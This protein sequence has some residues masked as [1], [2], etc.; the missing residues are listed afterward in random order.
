MGNKRTPKREGRP[1]RIPPAPPAPDVAST[2]RSL[3]GVAAGGGDLWLVLW[4]TL[5]DIWLWA[6]V[7]A[8]ERAGLFGPPTEE[9]RGRVLRARREAPE[10]TEAL[11]TFHLLQTAPG[12]PD[13]SQI[14]HACHLV[15]RWAEQESLLELAA[16]YAE[17]AAL[18]NPED[19]ANANE[20]ARLCRRAALSRRAVTWYERAHRLG[21]R[22]QNRREIVWALLGYGSL[23]YG[24]GLY[25]RAR[26]HFERV[27]R[28]AARTGRRHTA[29]EAHHD[30]ILLC[31]DMG[32]LAQAEEHARLA[33]SLYPLRARRI[34]YLVHDCAVLLVR[35]RHY[36]PALSMLRKLPPAFPRPEE[37]ALVWSTLAQAAAGAAQPERYRDAERKAL[38]LVGLYEEHAA[39]ALVS[40]AHGARFLGDDER[41]VRFA[42]MA[43]E[44]AKRRN[45]GGEVRRARAVLKEIELKEPVPD[46]APAPEEVA[47]LA[48]RLAARLRMWKERRPQAPHDW[49]AGGDPPAG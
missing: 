48:R 39:A 47:A 34:P 46:E 18:V 30:L 1:H 11:G 22:V 28:F 19:P 26:P 41:A 3:D 43:A 4:Q 13:S 10:L 14:S 15:Y 8:E 21:V 25:E 9:A 31:M 24:L 7:P 38:E 12:I 35:E 29:A 32:L 2:T 49:P 37:A 23:L 17:A 40:L 42:R 45:E 27:A 16:Y 20:A 44:T 5:G 36:A 33:E 6:N